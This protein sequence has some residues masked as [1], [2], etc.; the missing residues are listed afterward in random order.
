LFQAYEAQLL[1]WDG[2]VI[3]V[4]FQLI[5]PPCDFF[6]NSKISEIQ[7]KEEKEEFGKKRGVMCDGR[8]NQNSTVVSKH[9]KN[10]V[11]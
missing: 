9:N 11:Q 4:P 8:I 5:R 6:E 2:L 10:S 1:N 3:T 7:K